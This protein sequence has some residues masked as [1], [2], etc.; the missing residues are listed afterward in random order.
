MLSLVFAS[1][2]AVKSNFPH[3]GALCTTDWNCSLG[4]VCENG[5]CTCDP[6][7]TGANCTFLNVVDAEKDWGFQVPGSYSWGGHAHFDK[8]SNKW[9]GFFAFMEEHCTLATWMTNSAIVTTTADN[10]EGPYDHE[11][12]T[13]VDKPWAHNPYIVQDPVTDEFLLWHIGNETI[14]YPTKNCTNATSASDVTS[15]EPVA[16]LLYVDSS[17]NISGP[18]KS[19]FDIMIEESW[20]K[21]VSNPAP[22]LY[23]NGTAML[24]MSVANCPTGWGRAPRCLSQAR[25]TTGWKGPYTVIGNEPI[26]SPESEDPMVWRDQRGNFHLF[27][28]V[29]TYHRRCPPHVPCG[30][31]SWSTD[32]ITWSD[33][34]IGAF[35]PIIHMADGTTWN[36]SYIE[37]PQVVQNSDGSPRTFFTGLGRTSYYDSISWAQPFCTQKLLEQGKCGPTV[38]L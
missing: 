23:E 15:D 10:P 38:P 19:N 14:L 20:V 1:T 2:L 5:K 36:N 27:S 21:S 22:F 3:G 6:W 16:S 9:H 13:V 29:N 7:F 24:Y 8:K 37:R 33:Q 12:Y 32:G 11:N 17:N 18:W 31:H 30:G 25:S 34:F 28:N 26:V 35:G 4:G